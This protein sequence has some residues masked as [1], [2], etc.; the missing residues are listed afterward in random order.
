MQHAPYAV[1]LARLEDPARQLD[2]DALEIP[3]QDADEIDDRIG[4]LDQP[5]QGGGIVNVRLDHVHGRQQDERLGALA[6][7]R[8]HEHPQAAL[9]ELVRDVAAE[10]AG[11]AENRARCGSASTSISAVALHFVDRARPEIPAAA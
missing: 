2:V 10:E 3:V 8:R 4:G 9:G 7:A 11:A 1:P 5:V 6:I